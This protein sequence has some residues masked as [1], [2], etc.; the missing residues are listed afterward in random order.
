M[1][2]MLQERAA[3]VSPDDVA[4]VVYTSGTT[5]LPKGAVLTHGNFTRVI[6]ATRQALPTEAGDRSIVFL[7][8]AHS[9]QRFTIYRGLAEDVGGF[10][11]TPLVVHLGE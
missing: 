3:Q 11:C 10:Y 7:P 9:L 1:Q 8:L 6:Q 4:T 5:G 2:D